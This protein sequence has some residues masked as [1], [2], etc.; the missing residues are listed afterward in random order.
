VLPEQ[1]LSL[2][3]TPQATQ[4]TLQVLA[5]VL[6]MVLWLLLCELLRPRLSALL[7]LSRLTSHQPALLPL[8]TLTV[9]EAAHQQD[10]LDS[11]LLVLLERSVLQ[12]AHYP[13]QAHAP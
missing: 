3:H 1:Q 4:F 13:Q 2:E 10:P 7:L 9:S 5:L 11:L 12:A 8:P 6:P